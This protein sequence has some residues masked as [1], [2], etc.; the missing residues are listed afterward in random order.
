MCFNEKSHFKSQV[1]VMTF[2]KTE[3][4]K[5]QRLFLKKNDFRNKSEFKELFNIMEHQRP[6]ILGLFFDLNGTQYIK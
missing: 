3:K 2:F 1:K 6:E 4:R 5:S